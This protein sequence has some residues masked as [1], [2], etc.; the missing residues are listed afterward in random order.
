MNCWTKC[1]L[2]DALLADPAIASTEKSFVDAYR[3][4]G[5]PA[6]MAA[7]I[8]HESEGRLHCEVIVYFSPSAI[9]TAQKLGA[10]AC[11]KPA[12]EGLSLLAGDR[13]YYF[14]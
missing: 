1:N 2:G 10:V 14:L 9:K 3:K 13:N 6:N 12:A 7:F 11:P 8:R 5:M 4:A